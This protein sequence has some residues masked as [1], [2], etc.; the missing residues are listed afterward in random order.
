MT[1]GSHYVI[2]GKIHYLFHMEHDSGGLGS[3]KSHLVDPETLRT[4]WVYDDRLR[5]H[6]RPVP[7]KGCKCKKTFKNL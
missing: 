4:T 3:W 6:H 5:Q 7:H 1:V 2:D